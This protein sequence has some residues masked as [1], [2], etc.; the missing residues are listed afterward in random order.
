MDS[1]INM[2]NISIADA[3]ELGS[4]VDY[5][6]TN[7]FSDGESD[8]ENNFEPVAYQ[9][10]NS[11]YRKGYLSGIAKRIGI[12]CTPIYSVEMNKVFLSNCM[13]AVSKV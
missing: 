5:E 3:K 2:L 8:G 6:F 13:A 4:E 7:N 10:F 1:L 11:D 12:E 9:W